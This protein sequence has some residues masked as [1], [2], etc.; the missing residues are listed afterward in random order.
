METTNVGHV[1]RGLIVLLLLVLVACRAD[2]GPPGPK[3]LQ[4]SIDRAVDFLFVSQLKHGEFRTQAC[5]DEKMTKCSYDGSPFVTTFVLDALAKIESEKAR[6]MTRKA[7][8]FLLDEQEEGG[9]WRYWTRRNPK[10]IAPDLDD[11]ATIS[12]LLASKRVS[13]GDNR[14]VILDNRNERGL[15]YTWLKPL[16][17]QNEVDCVVNA[18]VL[19]YLGNNDRSVCRYINAA[20]R[21]DRDCSVYYPDQLALYHAVARAF[22][23]GITCFAKSRRHV[24]AR[25]RARQR[26]DGCF[27]DALTTAL[28]LN[29]LLDFGY[30][31]KELGRAVA[32][33]VEHQDDDGSWPRASLFLGPAPHY[34][35]REL[36]TAL[37]LRALHR[38]ASRG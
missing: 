17:E 36:T 24:I 19:L 21:G 34:G 22:R 7:I 38:F 8:R 1:V 2:A 3:R 11:T 20:I 23:H 18:N 31:G 10:T 27:G 15:F 28:A 5:K 32:W 14:D 6:S 16:S 35:S 30:R 13:F 9:T 4:R 29:A 37:C 25:T 26:E 12:F 33:L